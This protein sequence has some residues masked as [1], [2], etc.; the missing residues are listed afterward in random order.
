LSI[1]GKLRPSMAIS[2]KPTIFRHSSPYI[3]KERQ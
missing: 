3:A 1:L 2:V